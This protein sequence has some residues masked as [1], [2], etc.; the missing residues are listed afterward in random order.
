MGEWMDGRIDG[1]SGGW[2]YG[3]RDIPYLQMSADGSEEFVCSVS[4]EEGHKHMLRKVIYRQFPV[5]VKLQ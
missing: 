2:M 1:R 5:Y 3:Q 4:R